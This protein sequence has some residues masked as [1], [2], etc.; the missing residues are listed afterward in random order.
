MEPAFEVGNTLTVHAE[1]IQAVESPVV[2][3]SVT[4]LDQSNLSLPTR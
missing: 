2:T 1:V 3:E 4:R